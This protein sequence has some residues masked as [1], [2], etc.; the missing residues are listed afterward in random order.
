MYASE[1]QCTACVFSDAF[2]M[3]HTHTQCCESCNNVVKL[4]LTSSHISE[5]AEH[6]NMPCTEQHSF[7]MSQSLSTRSREAFNRVQ[8][9]HSTGL[10]KVILDID[11]SAY[12]ASLFADKFSKS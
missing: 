5:L 9:V 6:I 12:A 4:G 11:I 1:R 10:L 8:V 7:K 3:G 2:T